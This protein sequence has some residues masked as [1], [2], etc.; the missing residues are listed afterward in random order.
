MSRAVD[1]AMAGG[2]REE[3][4]SSAEQSESI[5]HERWKVLKMIGAWLQKTLQPMQLTGDEL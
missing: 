2:I 5:D 3:S 4:A 1:I